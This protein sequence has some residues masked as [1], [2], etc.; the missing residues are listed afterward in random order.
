MKNFLL[1]IILL[2]VL[3]VSSCSKNTDD[4]NCLVAPNAPNILSSSEIRTNFF[5]NDFVL[6]WFKVDKAE[7]YH[8]Q[9]S[10]CKSCSI[11][12]KDTIVT[13][14][15]ININWV[16]LGKKSYYYWKVKAINKCGVTS[17]YSSSGFSVS[18]IPWEHGYHSGSFEVLLNGNLTIPSQNIDTIFEDLPLTVSKF[19]VDIVT[20]IIL[21]TDYLYFE[22]PPFFD[23]NIQLYQ[24]GL[25]FSNGNIIFGQNGVNISGNVDA[26]NYDFI[27]GVL[28]FSGNASG[29]V[30]FECF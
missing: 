22:T 8:V 15:F 28:N 3:G 26:S 14:S 20:D 5:I 25:V 9:I 4:D 1:P 30:I 18:I 27:N 19:S 6:R 16:D 10:T 13:D 29:Q 7:S 24:N 23:F 21:T 12:L 2:F 11:F 17:E